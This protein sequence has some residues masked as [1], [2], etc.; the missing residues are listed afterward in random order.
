[1]TD[2]SEYATPP[3]FTKSRNSNH[4]VHIQITAKFQFEFITQNTKECEF[5]DLVDFQ[6][7]AF[8]VDSVMS[9]DAHTHMSHDMTRQT[10]RDMPHSYAPWHDS[11]ICHAM[12]HPYV[13]CDT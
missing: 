4:S 5:L 11:S 12:T 8:S 2:F 10:T 1:M 7:V 6:D 3:K 13:T 9:F